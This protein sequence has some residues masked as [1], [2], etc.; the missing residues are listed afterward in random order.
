MAIALG[1]RGD[2]G[3]LPEGLQKIEQPNAR[4]PLSEIAFAG[5]FPR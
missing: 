5:N 3:A 4:K 2:R 1:R